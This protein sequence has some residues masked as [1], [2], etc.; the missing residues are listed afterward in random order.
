MSET[1]PKKKKTLGQPLSETKSRATN[2]HRRALKD[3]R[4]LGTGSAFPARVLTS[5]EV[6]A[7]LNLSKDWIEARTGVLERH[8]SEVGNFS[9]TNHQLALR[10]SLHALE[11]AKLQP[12]AID[13]IVYATCTPDRPIPA[14]ACL[15]QNA[16]GARRAVAFDVNAACTGFVYGL[17]VAEQFLRTGQAQRALVIGADVLSSLTNWEDPNTAILFGD[18][19]GAMVLEST[20]LPTASGPFLLETCLGSDGRA[21]DLFEIEAGGSALPIHADP[22]R[23]LSQKLD[24][25]Q[26]KG[27][28]IFKL[29][30][31]TMADLAVETLARHGLKATDL[32]AVIPHQANLRVIEAV[33]RQLE[34]PLEKFA[35]NIDRRGNTS[36]A[37]VPTA[38]DA[39]IR[40]GKFKSGDWILLNAFGAGVT[41]GTAL[42]RW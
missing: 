29:A 13:L 4:I 14:S 34:L 33:A 27:R 2:S 32:R 6:G 21:W 38:L 15:L 31:R 35:I 16:L 1:Q 5:E 23:I 10:A 22:E 7:P 24:R 8:L 3:V 11:M 36:A 12:E 40:A 39:W 25:M 28:E 26:M 30:V 20:D 41:Y 18:G 17:S 37:T 19:A 42:L 9:E